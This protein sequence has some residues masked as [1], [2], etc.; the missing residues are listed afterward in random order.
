MASPVIPVGVPLSPRNFYLRDPVFSITQTASRLMRTTIVAACLL[1]ISGGLRAQERP[2][3]V[4][5]F[6]SEGCS[7]CPPAE[8]YVGELAQRPDVLALSFHV[9]YRDDLGWRD[10]F[11]IPEAT[12]R[13]RRYAQAL[14]LSSVYTPQIVVDG[15]EHFVAATGAR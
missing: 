9:D 10:H 12:P 4:E 11:D 7:S 3:V 1:F 13:Q 5:L 2:A 6:T 8:A 15:Y 14:S